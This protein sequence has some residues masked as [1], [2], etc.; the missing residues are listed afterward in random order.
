MSIIGKHG[1]PKKAEVLSHA[2]I[3]LKRERMYSSQVAYLW[4][5]LKNSEHKHRGD[6]GVG[7]TKAWG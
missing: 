3:H 7:R 1:C 5:E 2:F 6:M 4:N